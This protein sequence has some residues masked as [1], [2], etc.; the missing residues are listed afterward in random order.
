MKEQKNKIV[1]SRMRY[2]NK[3]KINFE[4]FGKQ[5]CSYLDNLCNHNASSF[6]ALNG[7]RLLR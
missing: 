3:K 6:K 4:M 2:D 5:I 7:P 1:K